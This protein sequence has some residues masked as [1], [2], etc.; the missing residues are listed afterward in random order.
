MPK[1]RRQAGVAIAAAVASVVVSLVGAA[2]A[3]AAAKGFTIYYS[4]NCAGA[5]RYYP[6]LNSGEAWI[7][8]RFDSSIFHQ[9]YGQGIR[10]NAA[11]IQ[12]PYGTTVFISFY[13]LDRYG[14][15]NWRYSSFT[16]GGFCVNFDSFQRNGNIDWRTS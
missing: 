14:N 6:G 9:G 1:R 2:P 8:D 3:Q 13:Q 10:Q 16:G 7:N 15:H 4:P 11:S 5:S 12:I